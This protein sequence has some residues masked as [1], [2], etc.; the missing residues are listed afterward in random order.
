M[1]VFLAQLL[2]QFQLTKMEDAALLE[3][4]ETTASIEITTTSTIISGSND[5]DNDGNIWENIFQYMVFIW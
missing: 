4:N 2:L 1:P 3:S 5:D